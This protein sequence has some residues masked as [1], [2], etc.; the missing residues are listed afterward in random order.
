MWVPRLSRFGLDAS[1]RISR[2]LLIDDND[3]RLRP[4]ERRI[5]R[6]KSFGRACAFV[7]A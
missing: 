4:S 7:L 5:S 6:V 2:E 3:Q 1:R